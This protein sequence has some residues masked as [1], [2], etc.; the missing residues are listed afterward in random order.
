MAKTVTV[1]ANRSFST[2][3]QGDVFTV[4][5]TDARMQAFLRSGYLTEV[6]GDEAK[7]ARKIDA[8]P[9]DEPEIV[10]DGKPSNRRGTTVAE[11]APKATKETVVAEKAS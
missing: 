2:I 10:W 11:A 7:G 9:V 1:R 8:M 3:N 5:E 6:Q 4:D